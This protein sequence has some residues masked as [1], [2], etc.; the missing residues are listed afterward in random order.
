[1]T[2]ASPRPT[3]RSS[4]RPSPPRSPDDRSA[5]RGVGRPLRRPRARSTCELES[6]LDAE[7]A[8]VADAVAAGRRR[9]R[10]GDRR[11]RRAPRA[12]WRTARLRRRGHLR[13]GSPRSMRPRCGSDLRSSSPGDGRSRSP[14]VTAPRIEDDAP[15]GAELVRAAGVGAVRRRRRRSARAAR[16]P[17]RVARARGGAR[18]RRAAR[19][20][21]SARADGAARGRGRSRGR[22][23]RRARD[24]R[25]DRRG[26]RRVRRRS[27][28]RECDLDGDDGPAR[29][30]V[31]TG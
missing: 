29:P 19:S 13:R 25:R 22:R 17:S 26:S 7:D 23:R 28:M 14:P 11:D 3:R 16:R 12:R 27:S 10:L 4:G 31:S 2:P 1:M 24:R 18:P 20:R 5:A 8:T 15:R 21:S 9:A 30:H 6:P